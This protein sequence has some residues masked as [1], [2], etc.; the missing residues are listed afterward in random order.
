M[1]SQGSKSEGKREKER[2]RRR[3]KECIAKPATASPGNSATGRGAQGGSRE[4][5]QKHGL[6]EAGGQA[7]PAPVHRVLSMCCSSL[8]TSHPGRQEPPLIWG[9]HVRSTQSLCGQAHGLGLTWPPSMVGQ[10]ALH[11][12]ETGL[13]PAGRKASRT[14]GPE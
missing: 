10:M 2:G 4:A 13:L 14:F 9:C 8:G 5:R 12:Q 6:G 11:L 1:E 3:D 7:Q